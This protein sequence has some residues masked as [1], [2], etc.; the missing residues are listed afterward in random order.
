MK[1]IDR[2]TIQ[3]IIDTADIVEVVSDFVH[4]RRRGANFIGLC[5]FH[6]ERTPSFSVSRA[7]GICKCFSCG[8]GG[9]PVNF[10][11]EHE[12][13]S[14][15]DAL[16]YLA[17]KYNIEIQE[18]E[19]TEA[20]RQAI[21]ERQAL[22]DVNDFALK[23]F[24]DNLLSTP[25]GTEIGLAYFRQRGISDAMVEKFQLGYSLDKRYDFL[26]A[27][28]SAGY[29][30]DA[31]VKTGLCVRTEHGE[32]Y[33]RFKG[34]VMYPVFSISGK[35]VAFGGRTL[36]IDKSMAKYVNSPE[37]VIYKKNREL[38]GMFQAKQAIVRK[39]KCI[40]VE[41]Y[42]DV[43]SMHQ[44]GVENVV[45]SSGTSLTQGQIRLI[46]RFTENVT[47]IYDSDAAGIKASLRGIDLLLAEG[48]NIK[49]LLLPEGDDPDS[50][51]Q[52]HTAEQ[53]DEYLAEHET[54]F[55]RFKTDVLLRDATNDPLKRSEVVA[56][57]LESIASIPEEIKRN[58]Y[59]QEC[60]LKFSIDEK[61]LLRQVN[62][63][64]VKLAEQNA[65]NSARQRS[66]D[67]LENTTPQPPA[68]DTQQTA[69]A[70]TPVASAENYSET[71]PAPTAPTEN[72]ATPVE[73]PL[74]ME[75]GM[76]TA[77]MQSADPCAITLEP[78]ERALLRLA[79]K[80]GM[81]ELGDD[82]GL[83]DDGTHIRVIDFIREDLEGD[84]LTFRNP[85]YEKIYREALHERDTDWQTAYAAHLA[86]AQQRLE[87]REAEGIEEIRR[88]AAN[89][90]EIAIAELKL[91]ETAEAA[92][93]DD[94]R[95][96]TLSYF[97]RIFLS[98]PDNDMRRI[99]SDL[100]VDKHQLSKIYTR[101]GTHIE[102]EEER[103]DELVNRALLALKYDLAR[104][105]FREISAQISALQ[106]TPGYDFNEILSLMTRQKRWSD[107]CQRLAAT[108]GERVYEPLR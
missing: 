77:I 93:K 57:I 27:A 99:C 16:R 29:S 25:D 17:R 44:Q 63:F 7:K 53:V 14:Y 104:C 103:I 45:A 41:G 105:H 51:A 38:Y 59:I 66:A 56:S 80:F 33:D 4:L 73:A 39:D 5:P 89:T 40:L 35:V 87:A 48:L 64:V 13:L 55:I 9:S 88:T 20:E 23:H 82:Y 85:L 75:A 1:A 18:H 42:M 31:M 84:N 107:F 97:E 78:Q 98:H 96:F 70:H 43:I 95:D 100:L 61:V 90:Q 52:S 19:V 10:I 86:S 67:S 15:W 62:L 76:Q 101:Q 30:D 11:M 108:I 106:A 12:Q 79:L 32:L 37:S 21:S 58:I 68:T 49:V 91:K 69:A 3:R 94:I 34:R 6:N 71:T 2:E 24:H 26:E 83:N 92:F 50:F 47:V 72:P 74:E 65:R 102:T 36:R 8:K 46:H 60:A 54:D 81:L 28:R 22:F